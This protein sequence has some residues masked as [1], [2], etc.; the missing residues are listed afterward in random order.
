MKNE[1]RMKEWKKV[2]KHSVVIIYCD[3]GMAKIMILTKN[4]QGSSNR[5]LSSEW[6]RYVKILVSIFLF[7]FSLV[8]LKWFF[9]FSE[10]NICLI[11]FEE[12]SCRKIK[13][14]YFGQI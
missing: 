1:W 4:F 5:K 13:W 6:E 8:W 7:Y 9:L 12:K 2:R 14:Y 3:N 10:F 11:I